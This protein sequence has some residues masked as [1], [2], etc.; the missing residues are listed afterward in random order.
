MYPS[1][2]DNS[3]FDIKRKNV[4]FCI[5]L[6]ITV[7][8]LILKHQVM[9]IVFPD[10]LMLMFN[11]NGQG[12]E[13]DLKRTNFDINSLI[14]SYARC[15]DTLRVLAIP[16]SFHVT[17]TILRIKDSM[18]TIPGYNLSLWRNSGDSTLQ[19]VFVLYF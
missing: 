8:F 6:L 11:R 3:V 2:N 13:L 9:F 7:H 12:S 1:Y 17:T 16:C 4:E 18:Y 19:Q 5:C 15:S 14:S 10:K